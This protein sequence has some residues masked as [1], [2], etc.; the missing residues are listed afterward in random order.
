MANN[1]TKVINDNSILPI[2]YEANFTIAL[3]IL[4]E[5]FFEYGYLYINFFFHILDRNCRRI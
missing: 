2:I 3:G 4:I 1:S 5:I